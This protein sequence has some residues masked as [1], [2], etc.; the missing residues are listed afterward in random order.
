MKKILATLAAVVA[1]ITLTAT[2]AVAWHPPGNP[3]CQVKW[4]TQSTKAIACNGSMWYN[5]AGAQPK[6]ITF[7][8]SNGTARGYG[9][10]VGWGLSGNAVGLHWNSTNYWDQVICATDWSPTCVW[11]Y[12]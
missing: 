4:A 1:A 6:N 3:P 11:F 9:Y 10:N 12:A 8:D 2:P 5:L 7:K